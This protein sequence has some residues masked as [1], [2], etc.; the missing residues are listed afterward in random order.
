MTSQYAYASARDS[1]RKHLLKAPCRFFTSILEALKDAGWIGS[2]LDCESY[3][4][5]VAAVY[6]DYSFRSNLDAAWD[7][8]EAGAWDRL[9]ADIRSISGSIEVCGGRGTGRRSG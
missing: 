8:E 3:G 4:R 6:F 5:I 2:R 1:V 7:E 9:C